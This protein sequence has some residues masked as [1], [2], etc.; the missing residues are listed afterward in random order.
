MVHLDYNACLTPPPGS[1][2]LEL[3]FDDLQ[4]LQQ[5]LSAL[6]PLGVPLTALTLR[7]SEV[8]PAAV[9]PCPVLSALT[10]LEWADCYP[11]YGDNPAAP[12]EALLA[13]APRLAELS[14]IDSS[15][16]D[17]AVPQ[18]LVQYTGLRRLILRGLCL[19]ALPEGPYLSGAHTWGRQRGGRSGWGVV[20]HS[21]SCFQSLARPSPHRCAPSAKFPE[22]EELELSENKF[23]HLPCALATATRLERLVLDKNPGLHLAAT[24]AQRTLLPLKCL[25]LLSLRGC[26][27][28]PAAA[29]ERLR[30]GLPLLDVAGVRVAAFGHLSA[31]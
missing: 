16:I 30:S 2:A 3:C 18:G 4:L 27:T 23:T 14:C 9:Q 21:S 26:P 11:E 20:S 5:L 7:N 12:L 29:L 25:R 31:D 8:A 13:Q 19:T 24:D 15:S 10:A 22:C 6:V 28:P 1:L 17:F